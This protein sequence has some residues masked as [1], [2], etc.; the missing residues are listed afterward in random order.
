MLSAEQQ[1]AIYAWKRGSNVKVTAVPGAGKT[2][3]ILQA[4]LAVNAKILI[5]AYNRAL[6]EATR[7]R[8]VEMGLSE[9]VLCY[10]FH[11]LATYCVRPTYDDIALDELLEDLEGGTVPNSVLDVDC[12]IIDECQDF[13]RSFYRLIS[14][15]VRTS[16]KTQTMLVGDP[17]QMLYDYNDEDPADLTFLEQPDT[18]F[19]NGREWEAVHLNRTYRCDPCIADFVAAAF[20]VPFCSALSHATDARLEVH[21]VNMWRNPSVIV[22]QTIREHQQHGTLDRCAILVPYKQ[23]NR[24]LRATVN[25]LSRHGVPIYIHGV[26]AQDM[27][28]RNN[29]LLV[30]TWHAAKGTEFDTVV[31]FGA[32]ERTVRSMPNAAFVGFTRA[33]QRLVVI[34]DAMDPSTA[35]LRGSRSMENTPSFLHD[36][37]TRRL[38]LG[39]ADDVDEMSDDDEMKT[40]EAEPRAKTSVFAL[41]DWTPIG[42]GRWFMNAFTVEEDEFSG[43]DEEENGEEREDIVEADDGAH[44]DIQELYRLACLM[45]EEKRQCGSVA[46]WND[47]LNTNR[48][49]MRERGDAIRAGGQ[50]RFVEPNV[51]NN[52]LLDHSTR[53]SFEATLARTTLHAQDWCFIAL[54]CR[55]WGSFHNQLHQLSRVDMKRCM[56]AEKLKRGCQVIAAALE[57]DP[58]EL[59]KFDFRL[60]ATVH[61]QTLFH[62]RTDATTSRCAYLFVWKPA[63]TRQDDLRSALMAALHPESMCECHNLRTG[64]KRTIKIET[65]SKREL[66]SALA[67]AVNNKTSSTTPPSRG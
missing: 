32:S 54:V 18:H 26:D 48:A 51:P 21:T 2:F 27:R 14:H 22:M 52:I 11:G 43:E 37:A 34:N 12:L 67:T 49:D 10:T 29:K 30:S 53:K 17:R 47:I 20:D 16:R 42:S 36:D 33:Q 40:V 24:P 6:C 31:V 7:N 45:S 55:A 39:F 62:I 50:R 57:S 41:D 44:E 13:R 56:N 9:R 5:L 59:C 23:N 64:A 4:C 61:E 25:T 3:V 38:L 65:D 58:S 19:A 8:L 60:R 15:L 35:V 66:L 63:L 28:V 1:S 46:R